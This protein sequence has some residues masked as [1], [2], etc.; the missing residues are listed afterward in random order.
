MAA[1]KNTIEVAAFSTEGM[2]ARPAGNRF[3]RRL[4]RAAQSHG[5]S[6]LIK[7]GVCCAAAALVLFI[8]IATENKQ[9]PVSALEDTVTE[10]EDELDEQ[11]GK[12][13][14]VELPGIIEVFSSEKKNLISLAYTSSEL[15]EADT[16]L[17]LTSDKDQ[18]VLVNVPCEVKETGE[19]ALLG[20]YVMLEM[21]DDTLLTIY[22][23]GE[24]SL[25]KGQPLAEGDGLGRV[26]A[27]AA[28][29]AS[30]RRQGRPGDPVAYL[31][32]DIGQ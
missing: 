17:K 31:N 11:L 3:A 32:L 9:G 8:K 10:N 5:A 20:A 16:L 21:N 27:Q 15:L 26:A 24:L 14:F 6:M 18:E 22:G 4:T 2:R 12:L 7:L 30:V 19:D 28:L 13:K 23:L 1:D 29:Y 25:E